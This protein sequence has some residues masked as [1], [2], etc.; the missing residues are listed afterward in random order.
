MIKFWF[1]LNKIWRQVVILNSKYNI[2][3]VKNIHS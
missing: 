3:F 1:S 2:K